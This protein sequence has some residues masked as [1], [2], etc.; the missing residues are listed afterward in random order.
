MAV[1]SAGPYANHLHLA[2]GITMPAP[3]HLV[4]YRVAL[5]AANQQCQSAEGR[6]KQVSQNTMKYR[7]VEFT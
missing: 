3:H 5:A 1:A 4:F 7:I 6:K 2:A